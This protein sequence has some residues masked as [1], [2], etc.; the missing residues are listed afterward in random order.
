[1]SLAEI[2]KAASHYSVWIKKGWLIT[3][4]M[5]V[6]VLSQPCLGSQNLKI[7]LST[8]IGWRYVPFLLTAITDVCVVG[9]RWQDIGRAMEMLP[10][11]RFLFR[12]VISDWLPVESRGVLL[13]EDEWGG[14]IKCR[15][16][17]KLKGSYYESTAKGNIDVF[18]LPY[19]GHPFYYIK[20]LD[21]LSKRLSLQ[22][23]S[24]KDLL[25]FQDLVRPSMKG[26][27][28]SSRW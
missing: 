17:S 23:R 7:S 15:S 28:K 20:S 10:F 9:V 27:L 8:L 2:T 18:V 11:D 24:K 5:L 21:K 12:I 3:I 14:K 16:H 25:F 1:M 26:C 4:A 13:W 22:G 6:K 19:F